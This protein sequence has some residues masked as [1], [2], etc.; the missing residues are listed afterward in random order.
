M[1]ILICISGAD[2]VSVN[3]VEM[4]KSKSGKGRKKLTVRIIKGPKTESKQ[5]IVGLLTNAKM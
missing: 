4:S 3:A 1:H 5:V 2:D